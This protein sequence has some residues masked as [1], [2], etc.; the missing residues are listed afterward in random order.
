MIANYHTHTWRC[1]HAT[2]QEEEYVLTAVE[3]GFQILGFSDHAPYLFPE[4][5]HSW[6]RM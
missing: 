2:G 3:Q 4:G 1:N 5:Y 6:V